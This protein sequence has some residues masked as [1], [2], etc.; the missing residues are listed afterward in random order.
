[1]RSRYTAYVLAHREHLLRTWHPRTRP[2]TLDFDPAQ[3]WLGLKIK[4]TEAGLAADSEGRVEFVARY[5]VAG[6]G[7]R[8]H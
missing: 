2:P 5:K 3:Q 7:H 4:G 6:R 1:M 8:L